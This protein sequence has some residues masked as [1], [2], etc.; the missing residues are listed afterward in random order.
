MEHDVFISYSRKD[1]EIANKIYDRLTAE[2]VTCFIDRQG[3]SGGADFPTVL[4]EAIMGA[5]VLLLIA[6]ENSYASEFT[7]K[8][9]TFAVSNKGSKFIFPLI[10][11]GSTLPKNLEFMLSNINWRTLSNNYTIDKDLVK[12]IKYKLANPHAGETLKQKEKHTVKIMMIIIFVL[13]GAAVAL[14]LGQSYQQNKEKAKR[15]AEE[16]AAQTAHRSC[17]EWTSTAEKSLNKADSLHRIGNTF[18]TFDDEVLC[19]NEVSQL[20]SKV[21]SVKGAY[22]LTSYNSMFLDISASDVKSRA[23]SLRKELYDFWSYYAKVNY[24]D[25]K[26]YKDEYTRT[27]ALNYIEKALLVKPDDAALLQMKDNLTK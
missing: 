26:S 2:G 8:E 12:D 6:S 4:S 17:L 10:V 16:Q 18:M 23:A 25:Y 24:N 27:S 21:D 1:S 14:V 19:L 22:R 15:A 13:V 5:K 7:Q 20:V 9:I 11:D 3:I